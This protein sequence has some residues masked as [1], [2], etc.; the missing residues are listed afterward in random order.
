MRTFIAAHARKWPVRGW[1]IPV[2]CSVVYVQM[3]R[4]LLHSKSIDDH[5]GRCQGPEA[6]IGNDGARIMQPHRSSPNYRVI[7]TDIR[8]FGKL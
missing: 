8:H 4:V 1:K 5:K 6:R 3:C 7:V 2:H